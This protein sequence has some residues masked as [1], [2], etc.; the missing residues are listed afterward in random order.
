MP[1]PFTAKKE[2]VL[3]HQGH[4]VIYT[5]RRRPQFKVFA[6][7]HCSSASIDGNQRDIKHRDRRRK[8]IPDCRV[9]LR[10]RSLSAFLRADV[11][12]ECV[13]TERKKS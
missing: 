8:N 9:L 5:K 7:E 10:V 1:N 6:C 4:V 13:C 11:T 3:Q 2:N 12:T